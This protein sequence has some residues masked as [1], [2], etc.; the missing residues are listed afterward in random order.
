MH[1]YFIDMKTADLKKAFNDLSD[2][3]LEFEELRL[4]HIK[5]MSEVAN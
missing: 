3:G 1:D 5:F 2:E 4:L